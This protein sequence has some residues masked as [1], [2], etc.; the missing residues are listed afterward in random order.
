VFVKA[1]IRVGGSWGDVCVRDISSRGLLLQAA[2]VPP[3][4]SYI[5]VRRGRHSVVARVVWASDERFG[6]LAQ[7]RISIDGF[8]G[9]PDLSTIDFNTASRAQPGFERRAA[10]RGSEVQRLEQKLLRSR[11]ISSV[12]Q[13]MTLAGLGAI[14]ATAAF[15]IVGSTLSMPLAAMNA[16]LQGPSTSLPH[17]SGTP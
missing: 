7:D 14:A 13:F 17:P 1:R 4:G 12:L 6:V 8:V 3:R 11:R 16:S 5:E 15:D 9:E 10:P 2:N